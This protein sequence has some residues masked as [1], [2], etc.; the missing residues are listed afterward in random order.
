MIQI[1]KMQ[2]LK[3]G[4]TLLLACKYITDEE[5]QRLTGKKQEVGRLLGDI[6]KDPGKHC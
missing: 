6:I 4:L 2:K 1:L 5:H 3:Y